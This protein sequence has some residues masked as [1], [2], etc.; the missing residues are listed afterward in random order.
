[1]RTVENLDKPKKNKRHYRCYRLGNMYL[2][3]E[4]ITYEGYPELTEL[5]L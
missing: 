3:L 4:S 2:V 1:M 5:M